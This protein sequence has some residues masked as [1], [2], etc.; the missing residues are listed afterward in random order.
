MNPIVTRRA[1]RN[2]IIQIS[3]QVW[4]ARAWCNVMR[5]IV[6]FVS[7]TTTAAAVIVSI[8]NRLTPD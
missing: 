5:M 6:L 2:P 8:A 3:F 4:P 7:F 1:G